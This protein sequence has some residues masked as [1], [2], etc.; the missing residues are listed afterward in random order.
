[1][2]QGPAR[3]RTTTAMPGRD[4]LGFVGGHGVPAG[5]GRGSAG[6]D[7]VQDLTAAGTALERDF[8]RRPDPHEQQQLHRMLTALLRPDPPETRP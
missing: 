7:T 6:Q 4:G 3:S 8:L 2:A 1:M 5:P